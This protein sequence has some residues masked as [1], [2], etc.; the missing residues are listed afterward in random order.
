[1][2]RLTKE[3][4]FPD[5]SLSDKYGLLCYGGDLS[6][7][8]LILAYKSGI[9]P[10]Y[11]GDSDDDILWWSPDPRFV[12][13]PEEVVYSKSMR[14]VLRK[15]IFTI[16]IDRCFRN[17][18]EECASVHKKLDF[19]TWITKG[20]IDGYCKLHKLG[21]AHSVETWLNDKLV[22]GLYGVS[23]GRMFFGES[24]FSKVDNA[25]KAAFLTFVKILIKKD[26]KLIDSQVHNHHIASLG[27]RNI[28]RSLYLETLKNLISYDTYIGSWEDWINILKD[29][30]Y[31]EKNNN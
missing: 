24:M 9:F 31:D 15:K 11:E 14:K 27:G 1:M 13:Y 26:F 16:T 18:I 23:I 21:Y 2:I 7:E 12:I 8:R 4:K 17:V 30:E 29:E 22:G 5:P 6:P 19:A 28:P 10:W 25:S 20:M 3:L